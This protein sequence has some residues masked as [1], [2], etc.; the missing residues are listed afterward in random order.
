MEYSVW[1]L[2]AVEEPMC[3]CVHAEMLQLCPTVCSPVDCNPPGS[4]VLGILQARVLEWVAIPFS[5]GSSRPRDG[6]CVSYVSRIG[7]RVLHH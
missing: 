5:R 1:S 4:S 3:A 6:T 7:R 2:V